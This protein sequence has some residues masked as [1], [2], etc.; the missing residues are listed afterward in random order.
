MKI[1][2]VTVRPQ[3]VGEITIN[4]ATVKFEETFEAYVYDR[5]TNRNIKGTTDSLRIPANVF[6]AICFSAHSLAAEICTGL[7]KSGHEVWWNMALNTAEIDIKANPNDEEGYNEPSATELKFSQDE[8]TQDILR[9]GLLTNRGITG[10]KLIKL[11][12]EIID[13]L[14]EN[15]PEMI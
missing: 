4:F 13:K 9:F 15:I 8:L 7:I 1:S 3:I 6:N 2:N 10:P 5:A 14:T 11:E 12:N